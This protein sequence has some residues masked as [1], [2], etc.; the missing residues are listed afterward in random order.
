V[1]ADAAMPSHLIARCARFTRPLSVDE[2]ELTASHKLARGRIA[3]I[4]RCWR[5]SGSGP[6]E[7]VPLAAI[8]SA[9]R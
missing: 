9:A 2:G 6:L 4:Y 1:N 8:S 5:A 3:E 7:V